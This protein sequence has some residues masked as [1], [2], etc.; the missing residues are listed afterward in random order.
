MAAVKVTVSL[1]AVV[2]LLALGTTA[3][4]K[5]RFRNHRELA[6]IRFTDN[7][8]FESTAR[9]AIECGK[10]CSRPLCCTA[11]T[12]SGSRSTR[13]VCRGHSTQM[14]SG[15]SGTPAAGSRTFILYG[16]EKAGRCLS[17]ELFHDC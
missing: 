17:S 7:L 13:G 15:S 5:T 12:F 8:L 9:S 16:K 4:Q 6:D 10:L 1:S 2:V 11:F 14:T 3:D